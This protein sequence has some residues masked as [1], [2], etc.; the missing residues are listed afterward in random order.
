MRSRIIVTTGAF[1]A[2]AVLL[3]IHGSSPAT[4]ASHGVFNAHVHDDY[5][6]PTGS[7][8][9]GPG[10]ATAQ[11]LCMTATPD[12][13]CTSTVHETDSVVWI[14]PAPLAVNPHTVT[15]C[16][17]ATY[18]SCGP[19]IASPNPIEDS[20][21]R[22]QPGWPYV[23]QF[24]DPGTFYY[25]CEIHPTVMRGV[26]EVIGG[27]GGTVEL[28]R[29]SDASAQAGESGE[30]TSTWL[31]AAAGITLAALAVMGTAAALRRRT[32]RAG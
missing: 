26:V 7:F 23:V 6:H 19:G 32:T 16:T 8:V 4:Q 1:L 9:P 5:F 10:H 25:R 15:E 20:G 14:A 17:D 28:A 27:V 22:Y 31:Y 21:A 30:R 3:A 13:T 24:N 12:S 11:A 18:S 2:V 29:R